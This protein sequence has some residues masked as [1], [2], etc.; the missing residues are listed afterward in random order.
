MEKIIHY[1]WFGD[2][3]LPKLAKKCLKSWQKYLPDFKI[4]KWSEEN[5]DLDECPFL[6]GAYNQ[7]KWAFVADYV[8]TKALKEYGGIYFDTDMEITKNIDHL[9][10]EKTD[11]FLGVEDSGYVAVGVWF[12]RNKNAIIP[13]RLLE[14]YR[15]LK[16]FDIDAMVDFTIPKMISEILNPYGL[17]YG[18]MEVQH[19]PNKI[20]I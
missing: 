8:R 14:Q 13:T 7:K 4:M 15:E 16:E 1:C 19:L 9:F 12:E 5:V 17:K 2:K 20:T 6:R 11:T 18:R 3:P 10:D